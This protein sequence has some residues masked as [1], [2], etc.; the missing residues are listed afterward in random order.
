MNGIGTER[1]RI[2]LIEDY[3]C[4]DKYQLRQRE[5]YWIREI[6]TLNKRIECRTKAEYN[7]ENKEKL[8]EQKKEYNLRNKDQIA[9]KKKIYESENK[10]VISTRKKEYYDKNR[11]EILERQKECRKQNKDAI[12]EKV[13]CECGCEINKH[14]LSR[15]QQTKKHLQLL[16]N[17]I[18]DTVKT[19]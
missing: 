3:P 18:K 14:K 11:N 7:F 12:L 15:H 16:A 9:E 6:G 19:I 2:D 1:F 17:K 8:Y 10:E 4:N 5:G 13:C